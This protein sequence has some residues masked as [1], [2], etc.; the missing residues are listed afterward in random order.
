M[1]RHS[2]N[3]R[4]VSKDIEAGITK[5]QELFKANRIR[6]HASCV[7]LISELESYAFPDRKPGQT[8]PETPV[9]END[10]A[11][12]AL[13]YGL[14]MNAQGGTGFIPPPTLGLVRPFL[15]F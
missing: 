8:E 11:C 4:E 14:F 3:V 13:R 10:H 6:V 15:G 12:D 1:R 7:N 5:V 2:L 9:K